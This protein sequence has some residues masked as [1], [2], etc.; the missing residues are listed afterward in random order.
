MAIFDVERRSIVFDPGRVPSTDPGP[1]RALAIGA[2]GI[3]AAA[4]RQV[5]VFGAEETL[6]AVHSV[7]GTP[8]SMAVSARPRQI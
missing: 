1:I 4:D 7:P 6:D 5:L 3:I 8:H 2:N